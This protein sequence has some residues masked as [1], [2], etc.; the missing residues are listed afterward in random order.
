MKVEQKLFETWCNEHCKL[1]KSDWERY[2]TASYAYVSGYKAFRDRL[3]DELKAKYGPHTGEYS[4]SIDH[5]IDI[6]EKFGEGKVTVEIKDHQLGAK[7][8]G[9][10]DDD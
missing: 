10:R 4:V 5:M 6:L 9:P 3:V 8:T 7:S 1:M 2:C